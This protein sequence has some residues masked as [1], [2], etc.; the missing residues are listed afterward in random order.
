MY[1]CRKIDDMMKRILLIVVAAMMVT[2]SAL[3][4]FPD[5]VKEVLRKCDEKMASYKSDAG[6]VLDMNMKA[7]VSILSV[8]GTVKSYVKNKKFFNVM[9]VKLLTKSL[10]IEIGCD[11]EQK[12]KY[13]G[14]V[15]E[16][17]KDSLIITKATE[18]T[19]NDYGTSRDYEQ[20]YSKAKMKEVGRY[21]E[22]TFSGPKKKNLSKK[23]SIKIDKENYLLREFSVDED[24]AGFA[25][26]ITMTITKITK[27]CSD[28]WFK[29]DMNRYKNAAVVRR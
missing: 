16:G 12:W 25:G 17:K 5:N 10:N 13:K 22:I 15:D 24:M 27:G 19:K 21:Y 29:L 2:T 7:K 26:K 4:Q 11:G 18:A 23:T 6:M 8:N 1:L 9:S 20:E 3:A 28:N 14:S